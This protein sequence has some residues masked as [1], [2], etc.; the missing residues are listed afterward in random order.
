MCGL[1]GLLLCPQPRSPE[2][3]ASIRDAFT[4][5]L[6]SNEERGWHAAGVAL[7]QRDGRLFLFKQPGPAS[8]LVQTGGYRAVLDQ[9]GPETTAVLGHARAPT[10][11][12]PENNANNHPLLAGQVVGIHNGHIANDDELF[13]RLALPREAEV[14][15]EIIVRLLD[16]LPGGMSDA[17]YLALAA[18]YLA[19]VRGPCAVLAVDLRTPGRLLVLK[20]DA[21]LCM[22][23]HEPWQALF[24]SSRYVFVRSAFGRSVVTEALPSRQ[25][26]LF[27][28]DRL[29]DLGKEPA[30]WQPFEQKRA[31]LWHQSA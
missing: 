28:A 2:A 4:R 22:H 30:C 26:Y 5:N 13:A 20:Y 6:L 25:L 18:E 3:W 8:H 27:A 10:K 12:S 19:L 31:E 17:Q 29:P 14:D 7:V 11:G 21:P 9:L 1:A 15:S 16:A 23:Y 24:F